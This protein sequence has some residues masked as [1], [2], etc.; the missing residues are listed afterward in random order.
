MVLQHI[1]E[2]YSPIA[3]PKDYATDFKQYFKRTKQARDS[4]SLILEVR[5]TF[6][7]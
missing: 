2:D 5:A 1:C 4:H 3:N 6:T 7:F